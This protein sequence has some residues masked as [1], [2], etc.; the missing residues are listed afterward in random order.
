MPLGRAVLAQ[1]WQDQLVTE[2]WSWGLGRI[3]ENL[4]A[5]PQ[6][7]QQRY[8]WHWWCRTVFSSWPDDH[9]TFQA[10]LLL[11]SW[12]SVWNSLDSELFM[13][14]RYNFRPGSAISVWQTKETGAKRVSFGAWRNCLV[15]KQWM[16]YCGS[17]ISRL[18]ATKRRWGR[19]GQLFPRGLREPKER[20]V[21]ML[22]GAVLLA[23]AL[24]PPQ[25]LTQA[26]RINS[27]LDAEI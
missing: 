21:R 22:I 15:D 16:K 1:V 6:W 12:N 18:L 8:P 3:S 9:G 17:T 27:F 4:P 2:S 10:P 25:G 13:A 11:V 26:R 5:C 23:W 19:S 24:T 14:F 20:I 7:Y